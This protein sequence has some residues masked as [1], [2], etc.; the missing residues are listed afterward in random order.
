MCRQGPRPAARYVLYLAIH[1][2]PTS[3][4]FTALC[5]VT[6]EKHPLTHTNKARQK[7]GSR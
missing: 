6:D 2:T 1:A 4:H 5:D 7:T 3:L